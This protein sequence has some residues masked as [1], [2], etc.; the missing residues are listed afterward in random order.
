[1]RLDACCTRFVKKGVVIH[2]D[3]ELAAERREHVRLC[4]IRVIQPGEG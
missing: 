3:W 4:A 2:I 1:M